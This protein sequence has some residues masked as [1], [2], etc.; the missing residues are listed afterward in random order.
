[1]RSA[2]R[3]SLAA[4]QAVLA[5]LGEAVDLSTGRELLAADRVIAGSPQLLSVLADATADP[6]G[7]KG[8]IDRVF[9]GLTEATRAILSAV[10]GSRWSSEGDLLEGVEDLGI[11]AIAQSVGPDGPIESELFGFERAVRSD[12][13]LELALGTKLGSAREKAAL[14][15]RLLSGKASEQTVAIMTH[16]VQQPRG[17]RIGELIR[18]ATDVVADSAHKLVATVV[19]AAPLDERHV[20]QVV[21]TLSDRYGRSVSVNTVVDPRIVGG[22]RVQIGGDVIDGTVSSR[23]AAL[24]EQLVG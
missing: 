20:A 10:A 19:T 14:V 17:R 1:M 15:E 7:K 16:L 24:R 6:V 11:R 4:A 3:S 13:S 2:T 21:K 5:D 22:V 8:I 18:H 12:A 23:V 9:A